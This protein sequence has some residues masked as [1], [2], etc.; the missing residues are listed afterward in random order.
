[1][2]QSLI[3][4][5]QCKRAI[6]KAKLFNLVARTTEILSS[7]WDNG[8]KW[9]A[10]TTAIQSNGKPTGG[11]EIHIVIDPPLTPSEPPATCNAK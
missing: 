1:M 7:A 4:P 10:E 11:Y 6:E 3:S 2:T 5:D 8:Q 9:S